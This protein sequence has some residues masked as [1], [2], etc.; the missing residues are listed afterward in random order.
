M[1]LWCWY[2]F[3][4]HVYES[5]QRLLEHPLSVDAFVFVDIR[6]SRKWRVLFRGYVL[7]IFMGVVPLRIGLKTANQ[8]EKSTW[9]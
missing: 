5:F 9:C 7:S 6:A 1:R 8:K 3:C 2:W 4:R